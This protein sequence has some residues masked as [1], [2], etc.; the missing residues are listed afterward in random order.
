[1][2]RSREGPILINR[3]ASYAYV[4]SLQRCPLAYRPL[5]RLEPHPS[6]FSKS[7]RRKPLGNK[8]PLALKREQRCVA[9]NYDEIDSLSAQ[10]AGRSRYAKN[11]PGPVCDG[12]A[13]VFIA[14]L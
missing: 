9:T 1:M 10:Q 7:T 5:G 13:G 2:D 4:L 3:A 6:G 14:K 11:L 8:D 12:G